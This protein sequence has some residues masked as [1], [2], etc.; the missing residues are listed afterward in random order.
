MKIHT[1]GWLEK[2][3]ESYKETPDQIESLALQFL[4][5]FKLMIEDGDA[6]VREKVFHALVI[7]K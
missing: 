4:G 2:Y 6:K 5:K 3:F 1:I 7:L